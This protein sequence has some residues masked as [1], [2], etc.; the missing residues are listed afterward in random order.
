MCIALALSRERL[1]DSETMPPSTVGSHLSRSS[2]QSVLRAFCWALL[3]SFPKLRS[4]CSC[5]LQAL[6]AIPERNPCNCSCR[7]AQGMAQVMLCCFFLHRGSSRKIRG[8]WSGRPFLE[9]GSRNVREP[10][11]THIYIYTHTHEDP[12]EP[13]FVS[14]GADTL[15]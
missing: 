12:Y 13:T 10:S 5:F 4:Y 3:L 8:M 7:L 1:R 14:C 15:C 2:C 9:Q 11:H 6:D